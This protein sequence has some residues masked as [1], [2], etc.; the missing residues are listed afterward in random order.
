MYCIEEIINKI[1]TNWKEILLNI[2]CNNKEYITNLEKNLNKEF[3]N[4]KDI[5]EIFPPK[6]QIFELSQFL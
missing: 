4:F 2:I 6:N 5:S 3:D 1:N